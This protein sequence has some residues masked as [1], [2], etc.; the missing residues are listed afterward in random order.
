MTRLRVFLLGLIEFRCQVTSHAGP[1]D[2]YD[3][4][5]TVAQVLTLHRWDV[6]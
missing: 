4:G 3:T 2:A 5:R 1:A 6:C